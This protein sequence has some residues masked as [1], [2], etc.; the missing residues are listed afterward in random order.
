M[1]AVHRGLKERLKAGEILIGPWCVIPGGTVMNVIAAAGFD[2]VIIDLEH[3]PASF[4]T[5]EE[6]VR[7]AQSAGA[8]TIVRMGSISEHHILRSLDVGADGVLVAHVETPGDARTVVSLS[9]YHPIGSRGFSPFTRAGGY[10]GGDIPAHAKIQNR[11]SVVGVILEGRQII[12]N[13]DAVLETEH[14]DFIY[15]GAYDLSQSLGMPGQIAHP[16]IKQTMEMCVEKIRGAGIAAGG[17]VARNQDDMQWMV[18]IGMQIITCLPDC[19]LLHNIC[20]Q[21]LSQFHAVVGK[22]E[23]QP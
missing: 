8:F 22:K 12:D 14:L 11:K 13:I 9:K 10:C 6:M 4:E 23:I 20:T 2:F 21:T 17:F 1:N 15:I 19:T 5:A 7:A 16:K 3:G 18:D